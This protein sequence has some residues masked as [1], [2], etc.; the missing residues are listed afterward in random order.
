MSLFV[1]PFFTGNLLHLAQ[2]DLLLPVT[3]RIL[4][5]ALSG[6]A[7]LHDKSVI[8]TGRTPRRTNWTHAI[9]Y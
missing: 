8:H 7:E 5:D 2:K 3:K 4:K 9:R 1:F 6:I